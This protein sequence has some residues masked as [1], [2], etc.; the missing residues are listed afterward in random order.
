MSL[1]EGRFVCGGGVSECSDSEQW[2][3]DYLTVLKNH[4]A[5]RVNVLKD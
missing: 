3:N 1:S 2:L 4:L 5:L